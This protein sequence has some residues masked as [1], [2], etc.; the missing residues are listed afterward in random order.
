MLLKK[1]FDMTL[2]LVLIASLL[3][4]FNLFSN[5]Q[6]NKQISSM[7]SDSLKKV[8]SPIQFFVTQQKGTERP[9]TG[10]YW[11]FFEKGSYHCVCCNAF[12]F[13]SDTK[14]NSSCGWPSFYD[15][16]YKDNILEKLDTSHGMIRTEVLCKK[17]GAHLGHVFNDGPE[18]TGIRYCVNSASLK[19]VP[20]SEGKQ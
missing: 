5:A 6:G 14:F 10:D 19:F 20:K 13:E 3:Y 11:N 2:R 17:C 1:Q 18:P 8:L 15:S 7:D 16:K 9:F 12:L 4:A